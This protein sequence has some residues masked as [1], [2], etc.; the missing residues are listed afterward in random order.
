MSA[1]FEEALRVFQKARGSAVH[2]LKMAILAYDEARVREFRA[3]GCSD[4]ELHVASTD[5]GP[6]TALVIKGFRNLA[7][8]E[9]FITEKF[10]APRK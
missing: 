1:A 3:H 4:I 5:A 7:E 10:R 2:C 6:D 8:I 9:A